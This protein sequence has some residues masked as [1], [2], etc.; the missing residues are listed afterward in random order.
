[1]GFTYESKYGN[2]ENCYFDVGRYAENDNLAIRIRAEYGEPITT[3]TINPSE[4]ISDDYIFVK[5][6]SE[7]EGMVEWLTKMNIIDPTPKKAVSSGWVSIKAYELTARG[8]EM[9][10]L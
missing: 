3:V 2:Y 8:K 7:N 6:Y 1:M 4:D 10:G 5:D 9:L